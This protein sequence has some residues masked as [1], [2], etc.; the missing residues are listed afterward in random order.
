MPAE[1]ATS[2]TATEAERLMQAE[3][4]VRGFCGWHIAPARTV[5]TAQI[6]GTGRRTLML[7][8]LYVT[9]VSA[10]SD[11]ST[12]LTVED[13]YTWSTAGIL[14]RHGLW[15][16]KYVTVTYTHGYATTPAEVTA[17]VQAVAQRAVDN[18]GSMTRRTVGPF[19]DAYSATGAGQVATLALLDSE[20]EALRRYRIPAVS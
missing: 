18:P 12:T 17:I 8:S 6:R 5:T 11:D 19:T 7:P 4:L 9:A 20:K 1:L 2:L 15:S 14:T 16:T 10:V 13:D 3:A